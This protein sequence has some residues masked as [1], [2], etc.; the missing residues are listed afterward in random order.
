MRTRYDDAVTCGIRQRTS[1]LM[2]A[3]GKLA[4]FPRSERIDEHAHMRLRIRVVLT[5]LGEGVEER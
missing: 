3:Y 4:A 5:G 2:V 1:G